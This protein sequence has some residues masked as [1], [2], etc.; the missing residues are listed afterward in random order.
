MTDAITI[1]PT[2][3]KTVKASAVQKKM[4][5]AIEADLETARRS[6]TAE[7][8]FLLLEEIFTMHLH[9]GARGIRA[10]C[11]AILRGGSAAVA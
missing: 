6:G 5:A 7:D 2:S 11:D 10:R 3:R 9:A 1:H 8:V 4:L